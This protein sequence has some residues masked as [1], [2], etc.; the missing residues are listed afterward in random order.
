MEVAAPI[1]SVASQVSPLIDIISRLTE[2]LWN[3]RQEHPDVELVELELSLSLHKILSWQQSWSDKA[4][5]THLSAKVLWGDQGWKKIQELL[6]ITANLSESIEHKLHDVQE[7]KA[8][9]PQQRWKRA[10]R[11]LGMKSPVNNHSGLQYTAAKLN[12]S[13]DKLWI[14]SDC[15][16]DSLH[17]LFAVKGK[18]DLPDNFVD[19]AIRSRGGSMRLYELCAAQ[20]ED[21]NLELDLVRHVF[22]GKSL[23]YP[24]VMESN[25]G[26]LRKLVI[27]DVEETALA[28]NEKADIIDPATTKFQLF[29]PRSSVKIVKIPQHHT[30]TPHCLRIPPESFHIPSPGSSPNDLAKVFNDLKSAATDSS[31]PSHTGFLTPEAKAEVALRLQNAVSSY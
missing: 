8:R 22:I 4:G 20:A 18:H 16:Y 11:R 7:K 17:G 30:G 9:Q 5:T 13:I 21:Y 12:L 23:E 27:E 1:T 10:A 29:K 28:D 2:E 25:K 24:L 19:A 15:A 6:Q 31:Y 3:L 26:E 14:Y